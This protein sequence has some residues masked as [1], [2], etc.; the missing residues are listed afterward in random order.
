MRNGSYPAAGTNI[1]DK[2]A[3]YEKFV[4]IPQCLLYPRMPTDAMTSG[5]HPSGRQVGRALLCQLGVR[6]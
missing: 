3:L 6:T 2:F 4:E 1:M 5:R